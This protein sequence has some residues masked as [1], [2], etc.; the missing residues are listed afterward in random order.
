MRNGHGQCGMLLKKMGHE[1][2]GSD[3]GV[4]PPM[5]EVLDSAGIDLFEGFAES[6]LLS[7]RPDQ[8]WLAMPFPEGISRWNTFSVLARSIS[9]PCLN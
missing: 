5:S 4:Y 6:E 7:W 9:F 3:A 1:V 2:A 8:W